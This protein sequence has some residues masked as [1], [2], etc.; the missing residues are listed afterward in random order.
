MYGAMPLCLN[1][2]LPPFSKTISSYMHNSIS[3]YAICWLTP[4]VT[5]GRVSKTYRP[6][7]SAFI[8]LARDL[9]QKASYRKSIFS[10]RQSH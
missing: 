2:V 5:L 6:I 7:P 4:S 10:L 1:A 8:Q 3:L 9:I